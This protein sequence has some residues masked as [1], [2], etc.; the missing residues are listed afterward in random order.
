[1]SYA[2]SYV[3]MDD[4]ARSALPGIEMPRPDREAARLL[5]LTRDDVRHLYRC[6][7]RPDGAE[8]VIVGPVAS[9]AALGWA[10]RAFG[11]WQAG[12]P[13]REDGLGRAAAATGHRGR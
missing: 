11:D 5:E 12:A 8:L 7:M 1:E 9:E 2:T 4:I 3:R 13:A 10:R 6:S